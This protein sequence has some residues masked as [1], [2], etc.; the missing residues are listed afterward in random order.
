MS[1]VCLSLCRYRKP[2]HDIKEHRRHK[3]RPSESDV[4]AAVGYSRLTMKELQN[5]E[6]V[7]LITAEDTLRDW[8]ET[9][10]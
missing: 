8:S 3:H 10:I 6:K 9:I 7:S 5:E 4:E 1:T 2:E